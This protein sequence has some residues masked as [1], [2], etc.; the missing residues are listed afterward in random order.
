MSDQLHVSADGSGLA[1]RAIVVTGS[2]R[3]IGLAVAQALTAAGAKVGV[4]GRD[5]ADADRVAAE[6]GGGATGI[7]ADVTTEEGAAR[8]IAAASERLGG[9]DGLVNN[10]GIA[11]I[12]PTLELSAEKWSRVLE[13]NLTAPF[14]CSREAA[15]VMLAGNGG[16]IVN[17]LSIAGLTGLPGRAAYSAT[18]AGLLGLTRSLAVEWGPQVRVNAVAPGYVRTELLEELRDAGKVDFDRVEGRVPAGR[19]AEPADVGAAIAFLLSP[20]AAYV[21]GETLAVDGGWL[22]S[23]AP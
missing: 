16:A 11:H 9:L 12:D 8:L 23:G 4:N 10:A 7:A 18:K 21:T 15:R 1:G 13:L 6:L 2:T 3:G 22:A 14:L 19:L 20:A 17:V 5:Q